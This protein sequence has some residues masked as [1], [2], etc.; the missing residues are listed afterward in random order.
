MSTLQVHTRLVPPVA[1]FARVIFLFKTLFEV[2]VDA[3]REAAA[4]HKRYPFAEW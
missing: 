4:A 2:L 3:Q 1:G